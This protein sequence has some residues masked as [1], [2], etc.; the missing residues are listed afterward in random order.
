MVR[1]QSEYCCLLGQVNPTFF[2]YSASGCETLVRRCGSV[3]YTALYCVVSICDQDGRLVCY[4]EPEE[5]ATC[6]VKEPT[7]SSTSTDLQQP[8]TELNTSPPPAVQEM[9]TSTMED[10]RVGRP[11]YM[12]RRK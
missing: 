2:F 9:P 3:D 10:R 8:K 6:D 7:I 1:Y 4:R 11:R 5:S 12:D